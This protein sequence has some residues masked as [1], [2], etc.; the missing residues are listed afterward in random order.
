MIRFVLLVMVLCIALSAHAQPLPNPYA[1]SIDENV[2]LDT[3]LLGIPFEKAGSRGRVKLTSEGHLGFADGTRLR[4]VGTNLQW[5]GQWPDSAQAISMAKRFR[6]LGINCVRFSTFDYSAWE[7]ISILADGASS[8]SSGLSATQMKKFDWF[9]HQLRENGVYYVFTFHS[10]WQPRAGDGIRQPDS[11]GWGA[12]MPLIFDAAVQKVHRQIV[13]LLLEHSNMYTGIAYKDDPALAYIIAAEDA[14]LIAYWLYTGDVVRPNGSYTNNMGSEH[15]ALIDSLWISWLKKKGYTTDAALNTAW[16]TTPASTANMIRNGD[17]EDP[18]SAA[19]QLGVNTESGAQAILQYSDADK[20]E[21]SSSGRVRINSLGEP[22]I[23]YS[24]Y[25]YQRLPEIKRFGRYQ[26][27]FWAKTTPQRGTRSMLMYLYNSSFPYDNYGVNDEVVLTPAWK[28]YTITFVSRAT[29]EST[30]NLAFFLGADS[31]DVFVDDVQ[32]REIPTSGLRA[33]E[34]VE[35]NSVPRSLALAGDV[36]NT[37]YKDNATFNYEQLRSM[38]LNVRKLVR[39]TIKS[40]V[41]MCPS[42]RI[43]SFFELNAARE[44]DVFSSTDWRNSTNSM[45]AEQYGG[46]IYAAA[47]NRI[48]GKAFVMSFAGTAYPRAYQPEMMTVLPAYAGLQDWDGIL[49]GIFTESPRAGAAKADSNSYWYIFDKPNVLS[50]LPLTSS[51]MRRGDVVTSA[52][53]IVIDNAQE[54][55]DQPRFHVQQAFSLSIA[56]D[57]RMPLFRRV[58]MNPEVAPTES[59][60]PHR[61]I[62]ALSDQVDVAALDAENEQIFWDATR[63]TLRVETPR[64][65]SLTGG[66]SGQITTLQSMIVEQTAGS[67]APTIS[68]SSLTNDPIIESSS[69]LLAISTRALNEGTQYNRET[70]EFTTWGKGPMQME[71]VTM[72]I[73][74]TAPLFDTLKLYPLTSA[75][76]SSGAPIIVDRRSG[77]KFTATI[78]TEQ[79]AT[80]WYRLVFVRQATSV[81]VAEESNGV[82]VS[83]NP[84]DGGNLNIE[85]PVGASR[86]RVSDVTGAEVLVHAVTGTNVSMDVSRLPAGAYMVTVL[87]GTTVLGTTPIIVR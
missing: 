41:L 25:L 38:F 62:S 35:R 5:N 67:A 15:V 4:I 3:S 45:L 31:G 60:L 70:E 37:R 76:V 58:A 6:S 34:S 22:T 68:I 53:E 10:V 24:I 79:Y 20:K 55:L 32:M 65:I 71:G 87:N 52:K 26:L 44:Y 7:G 54:A 42:T 16:T 47:Q 40:E 75:G 17:F 83:P 48:K 72:R 82:R 80:P 66:G 39:D 1:F 33:G 78:N 8:T 11:L 9:M 57:A 36:S 23:M 18:F 19:W 21:G 50:L 74:L 43:T 56:P 51:M 14:S 64:Y 86:V 77:G 61:E 28:Q 69:S 46:T 73:T 13:R 12:R 81:D 30:A 49:F 2:N 27:T 29:D 59:F 63:G 85:F 84:I